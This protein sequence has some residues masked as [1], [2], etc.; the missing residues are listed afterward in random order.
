MLTHLRHKT[1]MLSTLAVVCFCAFGSVNAVNAVAAS[2]PSVQIANPPATPSSN[3]SDEIDFIV[4]GA[5]SAPTCTLDGASFSCSS[6]DTSLNPGDSS[7]DDYVGTADI[8]GLGIGSHTFTVSATGPS[9][10][11]SAS[12]HFVVTSAS[13]LTVKITQGPP[14]RSSNTSDTI[15]YH[16]NSTTGTTDVCTIDGANTPCSRSDA[17]LSGLSVGSHTFKVTVTNNSGA[18]ASASVQFVVTSSSL[19]VHIIK[20]APPKSYYTSDVIL[21]HANGTEITSDVCTLD[22]ASVSCGRGEADLSGLSVG[23]HTF[24]VK[25][26]DSSGSSASASTTFT[27]KAS[28]TLIVKIVGRPRASSTFKSDTI[29][30]QTQ[31]HVSSATCTLDDASVS[32]TRGEAD[33]TDLSVG[34]H[35][36]KVV[37]TNSHGSAS[38]SVKFTVVS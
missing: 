30:Y 24:V 18:S 15:I 32:C 14:G 9:G 34:D 4:H 31:G 21:Y 13:G 5:T 25:V 20:G 11:N 28:T 16:S 6:T 27:V 17:D 2:G 26:K 7:G 19:S 22:G 3:T 23:S 12:A 10:S 1:L 8:S 37:V 35:T 36:F 33:L 38:A 29:I